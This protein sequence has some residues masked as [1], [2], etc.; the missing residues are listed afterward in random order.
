M[1]ITAASAA[2][3]IGMG[4]A[5][6][7][8]TLGVGAFQ[9]SPWIVPLLGV[10]FAVAYVFGRLRVWRFLRDEG[11]LS[12]FWAGL[13]VTFAA[14]LIL[15]ALLYLIGFGLS[16]L[17]QDRLAVA[18][19]TEL[20]LYMALAPAVFGAGLG[21]LID[22]LEG[23]PS[24]L[25][26]HFAGGGKSSVTAPDGEADRPCY[27]L[28]PEPVT[29]Q[30]LFER[31]GLP[32]GTD[33]LGAAAGDDGTP[34]TRSGACTDEDIIRAEARLGRALP[35]GLIALYRVQNGG[36][37]SNVCVPTR[38][39]TDL[40]GKDDAIWPFFGY[41]DLLP[42]E[43]LVTVREWVT[44]Y[45]DPDDPGDAHLFPEGSDAMI[46]LA[47]WYDT[48][49]FLDYNQPGAPRVGFVDFDMPDRGRWQAACKW[50]PDFETFFAALRHYEDI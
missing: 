41:S 19:F 29:P 25:L 26:S 35:E 6:V 22:R 13:P 50:W 47:V 31:F 28:L 37:V 12:V 40:L 17:V 49:L 48:T 20:D 16:V 15:V 3:R 34:T 44:G 8:L 36:R 38:L 43:E 18:P 2:L 11:R 21:W 7:A 23:C 14:Q 33:G 5:L 4:L 42:L 39:D 24:G 1:G 32:N 46:I 9:R 45:A 27:R 10:S 30:S